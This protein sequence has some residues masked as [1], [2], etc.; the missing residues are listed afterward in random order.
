MLIR[1]IPA[2]AAQEALSAPARDRAELWRLVA[3]VVVIA[4][5]YVLPLLLLSLFLAARYGEL[6]AWAIL[7]R[8]ARGDSPGAMLML[9]YSFIGMALGPIAAVRLVHR[10]RAGTLF[11]PSARGLAR[12]FL[13]VAVPVGA[14]QLGMLPVALWGGELRPGL[15]VAQFLL[16]LPFALIGLLI[17]TGGEELVFRGYLQ[18]QLAARFR[19]PLIWLGLPALLFGLGH[20]MPGAYGANA[21]AITVWAILFGLLAGD[22]TARTGN[23]G[24]AMA[25][26]FVNNA[27]AML[28]VG[29]GGQMDGLALF[30]LPIDLSD[31][32]AAG[33]ALVVDLG[34]M[35]VS[36]LLARLCLRV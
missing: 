17:Q 26:H 8:M 3:G 7:N 10:R 24:A 18:S 31:P 25:L 14:L 9:L 11:G 21:S 15:D 6:I 33:P 12:N 36:W 30:I 5:C 28:V 29:A 35:V 20:H 16:F 19:A 23:L 27:V 2:W 32:A 13:R 4:F 1:P 22:L 34:L